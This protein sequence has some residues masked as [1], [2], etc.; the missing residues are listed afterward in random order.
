MVAQ[1]Y[2]GHVVEIY[3]AEDTAHAEHILALQIRTVA[4]TEHLNGKTVLALAQIF[5]KVK[6][7]YV[8]GTL[9]IAHI[10]TIEIYERR[11]VYTTEMDEGAIAVPLFGNGECANV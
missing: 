10:L 8:I 2:L 4:P 9:C 11:A 7:G 3:I 5:C 6:F 1:R